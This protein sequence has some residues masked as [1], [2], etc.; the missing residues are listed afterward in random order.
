MSG[1]SNN[2]RSSTV[3]ISLLATIL[4]ISA[5]ETKEEQ[6][7][8][9]SVNK[10][11]L[12]MPIVCLESWA[13]YSMN[14][15]LNDASDRADAMF[16]RIRFGAKGNPY[17]WLSYSFQMHLDRLGEDEYASTKG[18]YTGLD[19]WNAYITAKLLKKSDLIN[20][21]AGYFWAAISREYNTS[22]WAV[23][24][25]DKTRA[26]YYL[27][28]FMTGKG[29]GIESGIAL[30]G[31]KNFEGF[32]FSYRIGAYSPDA[33]NS[34]GESS[35]LYTGRLMFT[36]GDPEQKNY[37]YMLSGN[38]WKKRKGIT[39]GF[40]AS[41]QSD[42]YVNSE[43]DYADSITYKV[44]TVTSSVAFDNSISYGADILI[45]YN[46]LRIEG[47]YFKMKRTAE[48]LEDFNGTEYSARIGYSFVLKG[49]F[50]EPVF[51][52]DNYEGEGSSK[53]YS[54]IGTDESFDFGIN[55]YINK[56]KLKFSLHYV[57]QNGEMKKLNTGD[58]VGLG[59]Q[60][61]L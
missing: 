46:G 44:S 8:F 40:G 55:W 29:N 13:T 56:D 19:I 14:E 51:S 15:E 28:N 42:A 48:S 20:L 3:I 25:F 50:L 17:S 11:K 41:S 59:L 32:G 6:S 22:P 18:K 24:S 2:K 58:Y 9:A 7:V 16:R 39:V 35:L 52:Y 54:K 45:D 27:R 26:N 36:V 30:G 31:L 38:Q 10:E 1:F 4:T 49:L 23:G 43:S 21:H 12:F 33:Y 61:K 5:Q 47:E 37:K 60:F 53:L 57:I 34:A